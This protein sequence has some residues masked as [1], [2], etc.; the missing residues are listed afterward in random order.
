MASG[1]DDRI[2]VDFIDP[3]FAVALSLNFEE[4]KNEAWFTDWSLIVRSPEN[5][6]VFL[7]LTLAWATVI[8]SWVGYHRSIKTNPIRVRTLGGW[9]RFVLD[10]LLLIF[11]S[12]L[13]IKYADFKRELR[14]LAVVF[15]L[16]VLW[17][18]FKKI[19][20]PRKDY[21]RRFDNAADAEAAWNR[22]GQQRG[23][24]VV[25]FV[26]FLFLAIFYALHPPQSQYGCEDWLL[27][28]SALAGTFL[29]R[30]HKVQLWYP[31][32]LRFLGY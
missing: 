19:E 15:F 7:T 31:R 24:T 27:L 8:L 10:V 5:F 28:V 23:V 16:F 30:A 12:I 14:V 3:L 22:A 13:L 20:H 26:F 21:D 2:G 25:W 18:I 32:L 1:D 4:L 29:Y 11:Y 9:W 17:D 6:F